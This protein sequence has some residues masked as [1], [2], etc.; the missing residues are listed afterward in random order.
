MAEKGFGVKEVNLIGASGTPTITSPN[1]LNLNANNVAISTNVSIG[2]TLTVTGNV[3]VGGTLTYEDVT[4]I[5]SVG[6]ITAREGIFLPDN[7]EAKF[8]NTA[9]SPDLKI[10]SGGTHSNIVNTNTSGY[11]S[12][13]TDNFRIQD[14][15]GSDNIIRGFKG[16]KVELYHND[17]LRFETANEGATV[18]G[19]ITADGARFTDDGTSG[20][21]VSIQ[22]DDANPY[23]LNIGNQSYSADTAYG[24]NFY[25]NNAGEGY[26]RF[27]G[28]SAYKD[29]H[30]S[31]HNNSTNKLCLKFESDDQSV[32]LYAEGNKKLETTSSGVTVT[33]TVAATSFSGSG[34]N[35]TGI[36]VTEAPVTDYTITANGS[37]AYRFHG[38]GV[39]ETAN[40]PPIYLIRGQKY[41]F[42]NTTGSSHPFAIRV[43]NGGSAYT[44]G[45]TGSQNGIQFFTVPLAAPRSLVYQCTAHSGMVGN[46]YIRSGA[47]IDSNGNLD[48][49][50]SLRFDDTVSK[51]V[52]DTSDGSDNKAILITGG[53]DTATSRGALA[54]FYGNELNSGRLD[55]YAGAGGGNITF[56]TGTTTTERLRITS[57]GSVKVG[58]INNTNP[59]TVFDVMA[60]AINQD[61]VRFTGANYNRGLKI[62]TA[63]SGSIN[64]ALIKYD[65]DSQ[66]SAGQ[67]AFLTDGTERLRIDS[68]GNVGLGT[69]TVSDSTGNARVF[70]IARSDANGQVRLILKNEA[71][72]FGNGAGFHQG[73]DGANVFIENR[74]NGG[75]ID[76]TTNNSGSIL[77]RVRITSTGLVGIGTDDPATYKLHVQQSTSAIA[78]FER[79][80]G[81]FA[82][83]D[84][85][86][87]TST[88]NSYLTFS[89]SDASEVGDLNYEHADN[90]LRIS[91]NSGERLRITNSGYLQLG[92]SLGTNSVGGQAIT[93][94]D[95]DPIFKIYNNVASKWIM[96][97][98][99]DNASN[100][101]G[102]FM[103]AGNSS[104]NYTLYLTGGDEANPHLIVRGDGNTGIRTDNPGYDL[105]LG[106]NNA[107]I[108]DGSDNTL[109]I[110]SNNNKTAIRIGSGGGGSKTVLIRV[111]GNSNPSN[112]SKCMG[113]T[114]NGA[115]GASI[116]YR[117]DRSGNENSLGIYMDNSES[118]TQVEALNLRQNGDYIFGGSSYS[119]QDQKNDITSISGT[120]LDKI[121]KLIPRTWT[122]KPEYHDIPSDRIFA[123]F[124]AQEVQPHI[125]SIVRGTNG[126]GDMS[127][128]YQGLL[129]WTVKALTELKSE[130]DSLKAR[131]NTL[132]GS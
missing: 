124:I 67:H 40:N 55:L 78:R 96:Q 50:G 62:S 108:D 46:I 66:N 27:V 20:P 121:T 21:T 25:N 34:A 103:R 29:Y 107:T 83:V 39:D 75:Y 54:V 48:L 2:G 97:L 114:D 52:T 69:N 109:R 60:S 89:D 102:I 10:Y 28:N 84:I 85:K 129:A 92:Q 23:A 101:N 65:A 42:N 113:E 13:N 111:D 68:S 64:D 11:L 122:W 8:G 37:S 33:G 99:N 30:F 47:D 87:G 98:R 32:E 76:L 94:Q 127:L 61:I 88:G 15:D 119:D 91:V 118:S 105:D 17:N 1:N 90:S 79:T 77:S 117:G 38:G 35:L 100:P 72:G 24:L 70:T 5:D 71:T 7:K 12:L 43:S 36:A 126:Q 116:T 22:T 123:G 130:N 51:I 56:N 81:A 73:I 3:S 128:D 104:S 44:D 45:V 82:K 4:N 31:L 106:G 115:Y 93:G 9:A 74:T 95:Y 57:G 19:T 86:A 41:R 14:D 132:E 112:G 80:G 63:V 59:T 26:F 18:T 120:A 58:F 110:R 131:V 53:G 49:S 6:I 125:P 16:G